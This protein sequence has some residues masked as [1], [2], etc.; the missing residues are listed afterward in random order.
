M[1]RRTFVRKSKSKSLSHIDYA[2]STKPKFLRTFSVELKT[3]G[4][5]Y[6]EHFKN[7]NNALQQS[8]KDDFQLS[9][10]P[11][12]LD[13]SCVGSLWFKS[14]IDY[15]IKSKRYHE[16]KLDIEPIAMCALS[17]SKLLICGIESDGQ[18]SLNIYDASFNIVKKITKL[19][20]Q[21]II[22]TFLATNSND[23][24]YMTESKNKRIVLTDENLNFI[25]YYE[26]KDLIASKGDCF[27]Y[28]NH[29]YVCNYVRSRISQFDNDLN[30][31]GFFYIEKRPLTLRVCNNVALLNGDNQ[32]K[33]SISFYEFDSFKLIRRYEGLS[34]SAYPYNSKFYFLPNYGKV[35][36]IYDLN[37]ELIETI[38][39]D[40]FNN[41]ERKSGCLI[42]FNGNF[43]I[44]SLKSNKIIVV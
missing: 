41:Q 3:Y 11:G 23:R 13:P 34:G 27:F 4:N 5:E 21:N 20:G 30:K 16:I 18:R 19:N 6:N 22:G 35:F 15:Q 2:E 1:F 25:K 33:F 42:E 32:G 31:L 17:G 10:F 37:G 40:Y 43:I 14:N 28:N 39:I 44:S 26:P 38:P 8:L 9:L 29:L 7:L 36:Q 12:K 24:V